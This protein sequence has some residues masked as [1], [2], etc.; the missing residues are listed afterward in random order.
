MALTTDLSRRDSTILFQLRSDRAPLNAYLHRINS[1]L[2]CQACADAHETVTHFIYDCPARI[3]ERRQL[4]KAAGKRWASKVD[5]EKVPPGGL[6][7]LS[8]SIYF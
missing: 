3:A 6:A 1:S 4:R 7:I 8:S 2:T 5:L